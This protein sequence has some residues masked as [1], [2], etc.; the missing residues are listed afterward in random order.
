MGGHIFNALRFATKRSLLSKEAELLSVTLQKNRISREKEHVQDVLDNAKD[1]AS[2]TSAYF[3]KS[4]NSVFESNVSKARQDADKA[5]IAYMDLLNQ[6]TNATDENA[7][8]GLD[9]KI[10]VARLTY[11]TAQSNADSRIRI[12]QEKYNVD[13]STVSVFNNE[14]NKVFERQQESLYKDLERKEKRLEMKQEQIEA[15][16]ERLRPQLESAQN[17]AKDAAKKEA[18]KFGL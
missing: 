10:E 17:A 14:K 2:E 16:L 12:L 4:I 8:K 18:P 15:E 9:E 5:N 13:M 1:I 11:T 3:A 7:K 6:K